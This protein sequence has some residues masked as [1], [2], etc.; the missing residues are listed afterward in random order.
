MTTKQ[1]IWFVVKKIG[2]LACVILGLTIGGFGVS[3]L[4]PE[5]KYAGGDIGLPHKEEETT[6]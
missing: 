1:K 3:Q 2:G 5:K 6:E 4:L